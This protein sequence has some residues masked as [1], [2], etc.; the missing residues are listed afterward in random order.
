M[1]WLRCL[2]VMAW[3]ILSGCV[4]AVTLTQ[5]SSAQAEP[6]SSLTLDCVVSGYNINAHHLNWIR[7]VPGKILVWLAA[8]RSGFT[9]YIVDEFKGQ[10]IPSTSG[11][12][13]FTMALVEPWSRAHAQKGP[14]HAPLALSPKTR[15]AHPAHRGLL[16][17]PCPTSC[18]SLPPGQTPVHLWLQA[19]G[20]PPVS[21][22]LSLLALVQTLLG[23]PGQSQVEGEQC[24]GLGWA[25]PGKCNL[26]PALAAL[27]AQ[28]GRQSRLPAGPV[29]VVRRQG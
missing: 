12:A 19:C 29:S 13:G 15:Q 21:P 17:T 24:R 2:C 4:A 20:A 7:Q 6:G 25:P 22:E 5:P 28:P 16:Y 9:I 3:C 14:R 8:F 10:V 23:T 11:S 26:G 27:L 1:L 18:S